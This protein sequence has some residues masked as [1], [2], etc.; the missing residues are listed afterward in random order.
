VP[1]WDDI[2]NWVDPKAVLEVGCNIGSN[3]KAIR[4]IDR[5]LQLVGVDVN[6]D[7]ITE[8]TLAG[9]NVYEMSALDVGRMWPETFDL[10]F[11]AGVLIHVAPEH[12]SDAMDAIIHSSRRYVLA[13]EY[14]ADTEEH[15]EYRG[16][17]GKLW[18][19]PFGKLYEAKGLKLIEEKD[20]GN[21]FDRC[22][23]WLLEKS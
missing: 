22:T 3:L 9:L 20:A 14:A 15:I 12:L 18:R 13:V 23:A 5:N 2:I 17:S 4:S 21:G 16:H 8:A 10:T 19:R 7:A 1:F 6:V 11:T